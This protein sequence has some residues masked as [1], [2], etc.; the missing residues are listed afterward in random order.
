MYN[1][2]TSKFGSAFL[3]LVKCHQRCSSLTLEG[4]PAEQKCGHASRHLIVSH[5]VL[6]F[7]GFLGVDQKQS[8]GE[9]FGRLLLSQSLSEGLLPAVLEELHANGKELFGEILNEALNVIRIASEVTPSSSENAASPSTCL[10]NL[11]QFVLPRVGTCLFSWVVGF[12][13]GCSANHKPLILP[14][15]ISNRQNPTG[16]PKTPQHVPTLVFCKEPKSDLW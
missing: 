14:K 9:L 4:S 6:L 11:V 7:S 8:F 16:P 10:A 3:Y 2:P 12:C 15:P 1:P 13:G 5:F